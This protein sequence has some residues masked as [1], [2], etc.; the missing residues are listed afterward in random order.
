MGYRP[1]EFANLPQ[2]EKAFVMTCIKNKL[3]AEKQQQAEIKA[4]NKTRRR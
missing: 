1:S 2:T 3:E 4:K